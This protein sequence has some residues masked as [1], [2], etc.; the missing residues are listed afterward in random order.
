MTSPV[1]EIARLLV[2]VGCALYYKEQALV[3]VSPREAGT[4][5]KAI[6]E[7]ALALSPR[8][9]LHVSE[10]TAGMALWVKEHSGPPPNNAKQEEALEILATGGARIRIYAPD[11][12]MLNGITPKQL[13]Q[14]HNAFMTA[15]KNNAAI[16]RGKH[17][18]TNLEGWPP[19]M[20]TYGLHPVDTSIL[21]P[22]KAWAT[23]VFPDFAPDIA[24]TKLWEALARSFLLDFD[25]PAKLWAQRI[26]HKDSLMMFIENR[27]LRTL[28][29]R[30]RS[31]DLQLS[32][33][34]S[35][36]WYGG[37]QHSPQGNSYQQTFPP[38]GL[39]TS[40]AAKGT[41]G[42][43]HINRPLTLAG[44]RIS[45]LDLKIQDGMVTISGAKQGGNTL[46]A[47]L[48]SSIQTRR[49]AAISLPVQAYYP[50]PN[51]QAFLNPAIDS[52]T[53][54]GLSLTNPSTVGALRF[55]LYFD[56]EDLI[57]EGTDDQG[58]THRL[59][60]L[61]C[62]PELLEKRRLEAGYAPPHKGISVMKLQDHLQNGLDLLDAR[63]IDEG[64]AAL[65]ET[66]KLTNESY[67]RDALK[68]LTDDIWYW[69]LSL[70][71]IA[72]TAKQA[73][74]KEEKERE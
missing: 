27:K 20:V 68:Q 12:D 53:A 21:F 66:L 47:F 74:E 14:M 24:L 49:L 50:A 40:L 1:Q 65:E 54:I 69:R 29:L 60:D 55:D 7:E 61:L 22:T 3:I 63:K 58:H 18:Q 33:E 9:I 46:Q 6:E 59:D 4:L 62:L 51:D 17:F 36:S 43:V 41:S 48:D 72:K 42:H 73:I 5:A 34:P 28:T 10:D 30:G 15:E 64:T 38:G 35:G 37:S 26:E 23:R 70:Q 44:K 25:D 39:L 13:V 8:R 32:L 52:T 16:F 19:G 56:D 67:Q 57:V 11:P 45:G 31:T 2:Q 71:R